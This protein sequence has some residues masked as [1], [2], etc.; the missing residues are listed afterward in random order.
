MLR[1]IWIQKS[2]MKND[3][4]ITKFY[5]GNRPYEIITV[6]NFSQK[7]PLGMFLENLES[8]LSIF[9]LGVDVDDSNTILDN[10]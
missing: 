5:T 8:L 4:L 9:N 7:V 3:F 10:A 1:K 6:R 2:R